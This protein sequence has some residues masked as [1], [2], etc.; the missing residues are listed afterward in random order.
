MNPS[1]MAFFAG[2]ATGAVCVWCWAMCREIDDKAALKK[3]FDEGLSQ[4]MRRATATSV[5]EAINRTKLR[6]RQ[7][8]AVDAARAR[9]GRG[10]F[11]FYRRSAMDD[12]DG[13]TFI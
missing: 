8:T 5:V 6:L 7:H 11:L 12:N 9:E 2:L 1:V 4:S 13:E 10:P 3:L